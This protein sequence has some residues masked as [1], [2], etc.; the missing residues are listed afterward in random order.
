MNEEQIKFKVLQ[1]NEKSHDAAA[2]NHTR[3]VPYQY[4]RNT[5]NYIYKLILNQLKIAK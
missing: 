2:K 1:E 4:R 3:S 5:R